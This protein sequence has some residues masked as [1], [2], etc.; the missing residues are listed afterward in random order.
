MFCGNPCIA[1]RRE[2]ETFVPLAWSLPLSLR[3]QTKA[4][5][6]IGASCT[7]QRQLR[8][9]ELVSCHPIAFCQTEEV[10]LGRYV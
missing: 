9:L 2:P 4:K 8:G 6:I 1:L 10:Q 7:A 5:S 3:A